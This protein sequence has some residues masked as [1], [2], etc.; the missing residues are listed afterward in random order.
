MASSKRIEARLTVPEDRSEL[1]I[2][3]AAFY[4]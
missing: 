2:S 4:K 1:V 3:G